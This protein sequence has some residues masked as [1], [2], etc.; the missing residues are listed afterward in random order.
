VATREKRDEQIRAGDD[1]LD[2]ETEQ[3]AA[4]RLFLQRAELLPGVVRVEQHQDRSSGER[5]FRIYVRHGDR[6]AQYAVYQLEAEIYQLHPQAYLDVR[7][8]AVG[9]VAPTAPGPC[10]PAP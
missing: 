4:N 7:V 8:T 5:S 10:I 6:S 2:A 9:D 1:S 3:E